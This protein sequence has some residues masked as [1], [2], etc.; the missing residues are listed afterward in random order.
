MCIIYF[1]RKWIFI[2]SNNSGYTFSELNN[3]YYIYK[4]FLDE[5]SKINYYNKTNFE[6]LQSI[7]GD[8]DEDIKKQFSLNLT[9]PKNTIF[10]ILVISQKKNPF[11]YKI[12]NAH[13]IILSIVKKRKKINLNNKK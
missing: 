4:N 11:S 10:Y 5:N 8:F 2:F 7:N 6:S 13:E 3:T 1:I 9:G 12:Y